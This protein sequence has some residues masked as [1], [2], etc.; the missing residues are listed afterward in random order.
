VSIDLTGAHRRP[1]RIMP[2][3]TACWQMC[4]QQR[5][6][7]RDPIVAHSSQ[8]LGRLRPPL[9]RAAGRLAFATVASD[10]R[11]SGAAASDA[12]PSATRQRLC[13]GSACTSSLG[14]SNSILLVDSA[15]LYQADTF[16]SRS[17]K[18]NVSLSP[19]L[20]SSSPMLATT[21]EVKRGPRMV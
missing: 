3:H 10:G 9:D 21:S 11:A 15:A 14:S 17:S 6:G 8:A 4:W 7:Y 1:H 5:H 2:A 12:Q 20:T 13:P 19:G 16:T 18:S